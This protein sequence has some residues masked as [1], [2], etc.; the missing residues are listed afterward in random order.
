MTDDQIIRY[1]N[2]NLWYLREGDYLPARLG[3]MNGGRGVCLIEQLEEMRRLGTLYP[4]RE[5]AMMVSERVR[6]LL[7]QASIECLLAANKQTKSD[8]P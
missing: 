2:E 8:K 7:S 3:E 6:A 4:T 1:A 5:T